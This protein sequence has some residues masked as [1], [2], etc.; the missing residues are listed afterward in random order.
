[1]ERKT[2]WYFETVGVVQLRLTK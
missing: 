1:V 2:K